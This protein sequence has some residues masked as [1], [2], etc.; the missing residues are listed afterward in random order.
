L[1]LIE[2]KWWRCS[3]GY[4][5]TRSGLASASSRF[6]LYRPLEI[7]A[8]YVKFAKDTPATANGMLEFC[9]RF[10]L[11]GGGRV[12][13]ALPW[14][15]RNPTHESTA[16]DA[17]FQHHRAIRQAFIRFENGDPSALIKHCNGDNGLAWLRLR[18]INDGSGQLNMSLAPPDLIR[19]MWLQFAQH[20]CSGALLLRCQ[21]CNEP[22]RVGTGT[23]RRKTAKF[24]SNACKVAAFKKRRIERN[25]QY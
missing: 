2:F 8:L 14:E 17:L 19:A 10:G 25:Q 12:D 11:L 22:I 24:C 1:E 4:R 5:L 6:D 13:F 23:G 18:L 9:N 21:N 3:D 7:P 15:G 20:A 16:L